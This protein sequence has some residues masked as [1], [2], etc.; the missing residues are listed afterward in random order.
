MTLDS[1]LASETGHV[2]PPG[3]YAELD[4][5]LGPA[6]PWGSAKGKVPPEQAHHLI[7]TFGIV[8]SVIAGISGT[9]LTLRVAA[10]LAGPAY[11]ELGLAFAGAVLI[12]LRRAV[13]RARQAPGTPRNQG[14]R[15]RGAGRPGSVTMPGAGPLDP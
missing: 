10:G 14:P 13:S 11:A 7:T 2:E 15:A 12:A 1:P 6:Q 9:V 3:P 5:R 4:V 8:A